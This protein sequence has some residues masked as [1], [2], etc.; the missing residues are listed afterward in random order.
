MQAIN[1]G[2]E[3]RFVPLRGGVLKC[4]G[5]GQWKEAVFAIRPQ[6]IGWFVGVDYQ[7]YHL[8]ELESLVGQTGDWLLSQY[9]EKWRHYVNAFR[10]RKPVIIEQRHPDLPELEDMA[11]RARV[12]QSAPMYPGFGV[13]NALDGDPD[14]DYAAAIEG[15]LP[16]SFTISL[17]RE[18]DV[19]RLE[20]VWESEENY[21][22][23]YEIYSTDYAGKNV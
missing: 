14:D 11:M 3:L 15:E 7:D 9:A 1:E 4:I 8:Q 21:A 13:E 19:R 2:N 17:G 16:Q 18:M 10:D 23:D 20:F 12:V 5:D 22:T 6:D